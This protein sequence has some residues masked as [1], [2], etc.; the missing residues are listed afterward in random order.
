M[1]IDTWSL[2]IGVGIGIIFSCPI[3]RYS[4]EWINQLTKGYGKR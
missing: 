2:L 4:K 3:W 1:V